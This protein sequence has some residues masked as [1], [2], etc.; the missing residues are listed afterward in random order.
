MAD[1]TALI[2]R[3]MNGEKNRIPLMD[4]LFGDSDRGKRFWS[5]RQSAK[6]GHAGSLSVMIS[7]VGV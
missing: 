6:G 1:V 5:I 7:P 3:E 4:R 2:T